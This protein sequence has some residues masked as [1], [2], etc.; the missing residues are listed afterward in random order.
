[1]EDKIIRETRYLY[2]I[3][4]LNI[5]SNNLEDFHNFTLKISSQSIDNS[6]WPKNNLWGLQTPVLI[7]TNMDG[8]IYWILEDVGACV[9]LLLAPEEGLGF[10][11]P[12]QVRE[13]I[14]RITDFFLGK[15]IDIW[16]I[17]SFV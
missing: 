11:D 13:I 15:S 3:W 2:S 5:Q 7:A 10:G 14:L 4:I 6:I 12:C 17:Y 16:Q 9:Q 8:T 1:M